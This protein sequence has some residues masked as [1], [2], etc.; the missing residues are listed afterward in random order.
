MKGNSHRSARL[1]KLKN[2]EDVIEVESRGKVRVI[3]KEVILW[4]K[5]RKRALEKLEKLKNQL[6]ELKEDPTAK[7]IKR[8]F[9]MED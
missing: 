6:E 8:K 9:F 1:E 4:R 7:I 3:H 2:K 5:R